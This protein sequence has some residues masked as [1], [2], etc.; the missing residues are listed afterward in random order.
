MIAWSGEPESQ[1]GIRSDSCIDPLHGVA[2]V[3][4]LPASFN[5]LAWVGTVDSWRTIDP[6]ETE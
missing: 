1:W 6:T 3:L 2:A 4:S 5:L